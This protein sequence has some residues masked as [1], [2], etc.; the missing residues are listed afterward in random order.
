M[1]IQKSTRNGRRYLQSLLRCLIIAII[2]LFLLESLIFGIHFWNNLSFQD[3]LYQI[4]I[5]FFI[6]FS[7][8]YLATSSNFYF[9]SFLRCLVVAIIGAFLLESYLYSINFWGD[10]SFQDWLQ[11]IGM[12]FLIAILASYLANLFKKRRLK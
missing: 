3:W 12:V 8:S 5:I 7:A 6:A 1:T 10:L 9:W 11:Q 4:G 2:G